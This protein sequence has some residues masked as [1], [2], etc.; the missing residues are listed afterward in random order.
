L[1]FLKHSYTIIYK[2]GIY[3]NDEAVKQALDH[4]LLNWKA[5]SGSDIDEA[6]S[7]ADAFEASF[8]TFIEAVK[9]W[10][11]RLDQQPQTLEDFLE[12]TMVQEINDL[13]PG[14]LYLNFET[15]AEL[16]IDNITRI[17]DETYD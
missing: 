13:L 3:T 14:P 15:E 6:E 5:M 1:N 10:Y 12:L 17:D 7:K 2:K 16:I 8:Y 9:E 11:F 4:T